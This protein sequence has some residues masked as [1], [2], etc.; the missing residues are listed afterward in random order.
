MIQPDVP[1]IHMMLADRVDRFDNTLDS[2]VGELL[3]QQVRP[4]DVKYV[5]VCTYV[6]PCFYRWRRMVQFGGTIHGR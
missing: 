4:F 3:G 6:D 2:G 5:Q 1:V